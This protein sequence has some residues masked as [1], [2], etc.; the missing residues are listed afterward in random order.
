MV[1]VWVDCVDNILE[2]NKN[3]RWDFIEGLYVL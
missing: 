1:I 2:V 3:K